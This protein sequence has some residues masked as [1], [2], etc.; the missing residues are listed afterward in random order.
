MWTMFEYYVSVCDLVKEFLDNISDNAMKMI[1]SPLRIR[2][3][4]HY[5]SC[6]LKQRFLSSCQ[7]TIYVLFMYLIPLFLHFLV[8]NV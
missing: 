6:N 2:F 7:S 8:H 3:Y 1:I 5:S 4:Y